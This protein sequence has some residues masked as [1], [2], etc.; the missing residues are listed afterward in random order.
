MVYLTELVHLYLSAR[1][2]MSITYHDDHDILSLVFIIEL[3]WEKL[4]TESLP[5]WADQWTVG[6]TIDIRGLVFKSYKHPWLTEK[7]V[8]P[9]RS[10]HLLF[11]KK[12]F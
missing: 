10:S 6:Q 5:V 9:K 8:K 1:L 2:Q 4:Q 11:W 12:I 3:I 7:R